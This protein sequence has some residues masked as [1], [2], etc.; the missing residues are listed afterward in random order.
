ME[1]AAAR[2]FIYCIRP[3]GMGMVPHVYVRDHPHSQTSIL[4]VRLITSSFTNRTIRAVISVVYYVE[5]VGKGYRI[6]DCFRYIS[7]KI[8]KI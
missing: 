1:G 3:A 2:L 5:N 7:K 4:P 6:S 8:K